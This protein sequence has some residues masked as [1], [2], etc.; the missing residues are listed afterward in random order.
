MATLNASG[1]LPTHHKKW[2]S[3][4]ILQSDLKKKE[5]VQLDA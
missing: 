3:F 1:L 2:P 4:K 5:G